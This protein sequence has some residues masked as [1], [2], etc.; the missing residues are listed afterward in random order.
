MDADTETVAE[1][2]RFW[3][4]NSDERTGTLTIDERGPRIELVGC[5]PPD[6]VHEADAV[7]D[8]RYLPLEGSHPV[9]CALLRS[10]QAATLVDVRGWA[11]QAVRVANGIEWGDI[12]L[13]GDAY[14]FA[15]FAVLD[16]LE[17]TEPAFSA[18]HFELAGLQDFLGRNVAWHPKC[19]VDAVRG[20]V[21]VVVPQIADFEFEVRPGLFMGFV[22]TTSAGSNTKIGA[23]S[24]TKFSLRAGSGAITFSE[25]RDDLWSLVRLAEFVSGTHQ[26]VSNVVGLREANS[27]WRWD[28]YP[29][30]MAGDR[31]VPPARRPHMTLSSF[32]PSPRRISVDEIAQRAMELDPHRADLLQRWRRWFAHE[33]NA[34]LMNAHLTAV[35]GDDVDDAE[36]LRSSIGVLEHMCATSAAPDCPARVSPVSPEEAGHRSAVVDWIVSLLPDAV[37]SEQVREDAGGWAVNRLRSGVDGKGLGRQ[38]GELIDSYADVA[39]DLLRSTRDLKPD[40][41]NAESPTATGRELARSRGKASHGTGASAADLS[42]RGDQARLI[43]AAIVL[44]EMGLPTD[45]VRRVVESLSLVERWWASDR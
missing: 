14:Y 5:L 39:V 4:P 40:R 38:L 28:R 37:A 12:D 31:L 42:W 9:V 20:L 36:Q 43:V 44:G 26:S 6:E 30:R 25:V 16:L 23:V 34:E 18:I 2:G 32:F 13:S 1:L 41:G 11:T 3:L 27:A 35:H 15:R 22:Q 7:D 19:E 10:R 45:R 29:I 8:P 17:D 33:P 24:R 21:P